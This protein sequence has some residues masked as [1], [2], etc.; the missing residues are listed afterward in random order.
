MPLVKFTPN[1]KQF[2]P[3]LSTIELEGRTV[4]DI[5]HAID[6]TWQGLGAYVVDEHGRLRPHVN[7]FVGEELIQDPT[8]LSDSVQEHDVVYVMQALSGG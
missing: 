2:F 7:I 6:Q 1:L 3:T 8:H 5:I 4:A